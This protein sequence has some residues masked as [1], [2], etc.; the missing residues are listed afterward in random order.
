MIVA[1]V[2]VRS[3]ASNL[4]SVLAVRYIQQPYQSLR[5]VLDDP[6]VT[7]IW[8][9]NSSRVQY[10]RSV[11]SGIFREVAEREKAGGIKFQLLHEFWGSMNTF[12]RKGYY[13]LIA[14]E[15]MTR[16]LISH[17]FTKRGQCDFYTAK[18]RLLPVFLSGVGK[19]GNPIVPHLNKRIISMQESGLYD[20]WIEMSIPNSTSCTQTPSRITKSSSLSLP[21]LW[22]VMV[23][24]AGSHGAGLLLLVWEVKY[25]PPTPS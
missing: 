15:I 11:K 3:Y 14:V 1:F 22:G 5:N 9:T 12:L 18:E 19:K 2:L 25:P 6:G 4:M 10:F 7:M 13:V 23:V 17:D 21:H 16:F 20:L 8:Q 24:L